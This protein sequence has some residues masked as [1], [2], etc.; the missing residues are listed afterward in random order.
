M[1]LER[2]ADLTPLQQR[3][4]AALALRRWR[5]PVLAFEV[6]AEWGV[7]PSVLESLFQLAAAPAGAE[8]NRA[9][10]QAVAELCA[11]PLF[12]S[13]VD[14]DTV[15][16]V[17]LETI[18]SLLAFGE[19]LDES[20]SAGGGE[21]ER[22]VETA[23]SLADYL[24]GLVEASFY[25]HPSDDAHRRYL[26]G[27][28]DRRSGERYF[29]SRNV[30]V[31]S[32][33]H[34]VL[35]AGHDPRGG[36][37]RLTDRMRVTAP[38]VDGSAGVGRPVP[39]AGPAAVTGR[40]QRGHLAYEAELLRAIDIGGR[41]HQGDQRHEPRCL[42]VVPVEGVPARA[43]GGPRQRPDLKIWVDGRGVPPKSDVLDG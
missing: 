41:R 13:E 10:R 25:S 30:A 20:G 27:L 36:L 4:A 6:D 21:A 16:L 37:L 28:A 43:G 18:S 35:R 2:F 5:A 9:Y 42:V 15:Q 12:T 8:S 33:C 29:T 24:D 23:S 39:A 26:A 7:D 22:V 3:Q 17:Q 11:A 32:A 19:S 40:Q 1:Q 14:P 31:E 38:G 34:G